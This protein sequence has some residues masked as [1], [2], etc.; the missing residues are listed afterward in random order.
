MQCD[1][2]LPSMVLQQSSS[3]SLSDAAKMAQKLVSF[4]ASSSTSSSSTSSS[5]TSSS[6]SSTPM[7]KNSFEV[8]DTE[9]R[10]FYRIEYTLA[11]LLASLPA[12]IAKQKSSSSATSAVER[13]VL[14]CI[15][16]LEKA[17]AHRQYSS[18]LRFCRLFCVIAT[19]IGKKSNDNVNVDVDENDEVINNELAKFEKRSKGEGDNMNDEDCEDISVD[20][21]DNLLFSLSTLSP[22]SSSSSSSNSSSS[23]I[24]FSVETL[25]VIVQVSCVAARVIGGIASAA[26]KQTTR[27][28]GLRTR[29][30][31][32]GLGCS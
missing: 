13:L 16:T 7:P 29:S 6:S 32:L 11:I 19:L 1:P 24:V 31:I 22:T 10:H 8:N 5:S 25:K 14:Q 12:R 27:G 3:L 30:P 9:E 28:G 18:C 17:G 21:C 15:V 23:G 20:D 4:L 26:V 2:R